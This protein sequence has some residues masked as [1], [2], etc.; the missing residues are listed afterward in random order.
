MN[1]YATMDTP[2]GELVVRE[3]YRVERHQVRR[4]RRAGRPAR[5]PFWSRLLPRRDDLEQSLRR[6]RPRFPLDR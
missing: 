1:P 2:A 6:L 5:P 3:E 4:V